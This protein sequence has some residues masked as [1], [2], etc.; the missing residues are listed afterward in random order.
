MNARARPYYMT[1]SAQENPTCVPVAR[2]EG[3]HFILESGAVLQDMLSTSFQA[4]FGHNH[5]H[6]L[7][8]LRGQLEG[9]MVAFP[10]ADFELKK[11]ATA[12]LLE[13]LG[14]DGGKIFY[15]VSG[16]E[17]IENAVK[18]ARQVRGADIIL[19][20]SNSYHGAS[21]G[22]LSITG[23]WRN[24]AHHTV[25]QWTVRIPEPDAPGALEA[26]RRAILET[27]PGKIAGFCL[28]SISG[29][30][31][32][33]T[34][35]AAWWEGIQELCD[36]FGLFLILDEVLCGFNRTGRPFAFQG[37]PVRPHFVVMG[38]AISAGYVPFGAVWTHVK[39]AD[40]YAERTFAAGLTNYAHPLGLAAMEGVL[41]VL[42]DEEFLRSVKEL[43]SAFQTEM[44]ALAE[45]PAVK[46]MRCHGLL[47]AADF[48]RPGEFRWQDFA[49]AGVH[50]L[51]NDTR[52]VLCPPMVMTRQEL[53]TGFAA[54]RKVVSGGRAP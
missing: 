46:A 28:E 54:I 20:R 15:T 10:K 16:A 25:D 49:E 9:L 38:K 17:G 11:R 13:Y 2:A 32:V 43:E 5:A 39:I 3:S 12:R 6:I 41:D 26:T 21:L 29:A 8:K 45:D 37:F 48:S 22:A 31:G 50:L 27:G 18:L 40:Y 42:T 7:E 53:E 51:C 19:A 33:I 14:L 47:G 36:E 52:L 24:K 1:W 23:D 44:R 35:D 30:N 34:G 4:G